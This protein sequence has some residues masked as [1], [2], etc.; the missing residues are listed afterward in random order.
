MAAD[1]FYIEIFEQIAKDGFFSYERSASPEYKDAV[2]ILRDEG[3]INNHGGGYRFV[4]LFKGTEVVKQGGW[5]KHIV[6]LD[7][8]KTHFKKKRAI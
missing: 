7:K 2:R 3:Y 4:P 5:Q 8:F 6:A 1:R